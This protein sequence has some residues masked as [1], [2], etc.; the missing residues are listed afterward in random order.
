[1]TTVSIDSTQTD[2]ESSSSILS[3]SCES[4]I[5][6]VEELAE[7]IFSQVQE[8]EFDFQSVYFENVIYLVQTKKGA[9]RLLLEPLGELYG[10]GT[11]FRVEKYR[12][13]L[14][15]KRW[16]V[17]IGRDSSISQMEKYLKRSY[18][19]MNEL[20]L[21]SDGEERVALKAYLGTSHP[22]IGRVSYLVMEPCEGGELW[23][24]VASGEGLKIPIFNRLQ[25][26]RK[27]VAAVAFWHRKNFSPGDV[28]LENFLRKKDFWDSEVVLV[29]LDG[30]IDPEKELERK[31]I[32]SFE[33][34]ITP[35]YLLDEDEDAN[36]LAIDEGNRKQVSEIR[37]ARDV[38]ATMI[39][40]LQICFLI[41]DVEW[42]I[43]R[44][45]K[46]EM[47]QLNVK[48]KLKEQFDA[49]LA[50]RLSQFQTQ[51]LKKVCKE[52]LLE[53]WESRPSIESLLTAV[54]EELAFQ[55]SFATSN[56]TLK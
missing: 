12:D 55:S 50:D 15:D 29:D 43:V 21:G 47:K 5:E 49:L 13:L 35:D 27:V 4:L 36:V 28:K 16:A 48:S 33:R 44:L 7:K 46:G 9:E 31:D 22:T 26:A 6:R 52:A 51:K 56:Q 53:N 8:T 10:K 40:F 42:Q 17:R 38:F 34:I 20:A 32:Y 19:R 3:S 41:P 30:V 37:K 18:E 24:W 11:F 1:M 54:D 23:E 14:T 25:V 45:G 39:T 2:L